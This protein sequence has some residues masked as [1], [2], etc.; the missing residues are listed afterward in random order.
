MISGA[1]D[2]VD[3]HIVETY[4][5][6]IYVKD[7]LTSEITKTKNKLTSAFHTIGLLKSIDKVTKRYLFLDIILISSKICSEV[8]ILIQKDLSNKV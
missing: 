1:I 8:E 3:R 6:F 2:N 7:N 5:Y 4:V